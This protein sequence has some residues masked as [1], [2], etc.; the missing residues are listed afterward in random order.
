MAHDSLVRPPAADRLHATCPVCDS[1]VPE[2]RLVLRDHQSDETFAAVTCGTCGA[3]YLEDPPTPEAIGRYYD[4]PA[5]AQMHTK[6]GPLFT[7]MRDRR[8]AKDLEP[9]LTRLNPDAPIADLGTGD[10]SVAEHLHR[11]G[12]AS[13]GLDV[14]DPSAW[15]HPDVPYRQISFAGPGLSAED[16]A[17]AGTQARGAVMRHVLEHVHRPAD[18]LASLRAGGVT[19]VLI[20]VPNIGSRLVG[21]LGSSWY[22]WDPPRHLTFFTA[23]TLRRCA[24]RAGFRVAALDTY[25]LD[26]LA[27]SAHR[28]LLLRGGARAH[29]IARAL[30]PTGPIAGAA[31]VL[32]GPVGDTVLHA[33]L[34]ADDR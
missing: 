9:L 24:A 33:V 2:L 30:R 32:Q 7:A 6:P 3:V 21:P 34:V 31:S 13:L 19:H 25:G 5:G 22:Y 16:L 28:A 15:R 1:D 4:T 10:G 14:Y 29:K 17:V 18:V 20:I 27:T 12:R 8:F 11:H 23:D 26:E